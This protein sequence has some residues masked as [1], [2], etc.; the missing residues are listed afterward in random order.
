MGEPKKDF[1][2]RNTIDFIFL[3]QGDARQEPKQL[4]PLSVIISTIRLKKKLNQRN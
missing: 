2:S 3:L 4:Y 1:I